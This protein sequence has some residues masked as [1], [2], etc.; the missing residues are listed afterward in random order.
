MTD[1]TPDPTKLVITI[2][3]TIEVP[4]ESVLTSDHAA[5][6]A[7]ITPAVEAI[8]AALEPIQTALAVPTDASIEFTVDAGHAWSTPAPTA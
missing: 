3:S 6:M 5:G 2:T 4:A 8:A 1:T 7:L